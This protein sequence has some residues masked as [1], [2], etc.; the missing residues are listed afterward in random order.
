MAQLPPVWRIPHS[1]ES[2]LPWEVMVIGNRGG[3][4]VAKE[5]VEPAWL[6]NQLVAKV[7]ENG[8]RWLNVVVYDTAH[9]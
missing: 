1:W 7:K 6:I 2:P 3:R 5:A 9:K 8:I 4:P